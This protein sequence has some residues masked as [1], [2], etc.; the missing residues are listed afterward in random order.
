MMSKSL[1][2]LSLGRQKTP[3]ICK[4]AKNFR[5]YHCD[6]KV[7]G[8]NAVA[9]KRKR[10][11]SLSEFQ[12]FQVFI[13]K[14]PTDLTEN[15]LVNVEFLTCTLSSAHAFFSARLLQRSPSSEHAF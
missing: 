3:K 6:G 11:E 14:C 2:L 1:T 13:S 4:L 5:L 7:F 15:S 12:Y 8:Y 10:Q 9:W